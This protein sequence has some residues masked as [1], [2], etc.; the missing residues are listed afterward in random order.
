[1]RSMNSLM[2]SNFPRRAKGTP[3][4]NGKP[5]LGEKICHV[6]FVISSSRQQTKFKYQQNGRT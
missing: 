2:H 1:M 4:E 5:S 3:C 6:N